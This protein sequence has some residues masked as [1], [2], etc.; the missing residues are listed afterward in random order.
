MT[1]PKRAAI[2]LAITDA[3]L[4]RAHCSVARARAPS[5]VTAASFFG[6]SGRSLRSMYT[7]QPM[8]AARILLAEDDPSTLEALQSTLRA[9]GFAPHP[10]A[11]GALA[12]AALQRS[13]F[14]ML[15]SDVNM[16]ALDGFSLC[17]R[18]REHDAAM[19]IV[20]L[21]SRDS[22]M[23]EAL[24]LELGA[25]DYLCKPFS[26]R[27]LLARI[28]GLLRRAT[29]APS[30]ARSAFVL[31]PLEIDRDRLEARWHGAL[32]DTTVT[33]LRMIEALATRAGRVLSRAQL[34][35]L[36]RE[37]D[38]IV[39]PRI[40]DTYIARIR[41]KFDAARAASD[42]IETVIGAGYRYRAER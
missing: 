27:I 8:S 1:A 21:T 12:W 11:D 29:R 7:A 6:S 41:K 4:E 3:P 42:P 31:G 30:D 26:T 33:E 23:D 15:V 36:G 9:E 22:E 17:R 32:L 40:V 13:R 20:L 25:D 35:Q 2:T 10:C 38:S 14:D 16:P 24:G 5:L 18:A 39:A 37:D 19:P 34:L 28:R